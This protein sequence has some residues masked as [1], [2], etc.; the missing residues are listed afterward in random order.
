MGRSFLVPITALRRPLASCE[1]PSKPL[2]CI[3]PA[4]ASRQIA[5]DRARPVTGVLCL[6]LQQSKKL[7]GV[8]LRFLGSGEFAV[9]S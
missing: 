2:R 6:L 1:R 7:G 3:A 5:G 9:D 4:I 8:Q